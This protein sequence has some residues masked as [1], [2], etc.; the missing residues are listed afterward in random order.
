MAHDHA[1]AERIR[2]IL[3]AEPDLTERRMFGGLAFLIG[4]HMAV[5]VSGRG[6]GLMVKVDPDDRAEMLETTAARVTRMGDREMTGWVDLDADA[7]STDAELERWVE[8]GA[9]IARAL[10]PKAPKAPPAS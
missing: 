1:L 4:G 6:D 10:P 7:V 5:A 3:A 9:N 2:T 8:I